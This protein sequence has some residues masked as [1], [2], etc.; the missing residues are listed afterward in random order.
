MD[1]PINECKLDSLNWVLH[2]AL[3]IGIDAR[4]INDLGIQDYRN[5]V[6]DYTDSG[7]NHIAFTVQDI[8][9]LIKSGDELEVYLSG[10]ALVT[11]K[12]PEVQEEILLKYED[13]HGTALPEFHDYDV[14][15]GDKPTKVF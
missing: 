2:E 8:S 12:D 9:L 15:N 10:A 14:N 3:K 5:A 6:I 13:A 11:V 1:F 4:G 7:G